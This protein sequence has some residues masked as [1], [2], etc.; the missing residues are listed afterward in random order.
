M[1]VLIAGAG[2]AGLSLGIRLRAAGIDATVIEKTDLTGPAGSGLSLFRNGL[3]ALDALGLG[4]P[5]RDACGTPYVPATSGLRSSSGR[6][7]TRT[8][9]RITASLLVVDREVLRETLVSLLPPDA[10]RTSEAVIRVRENGGV[11]TGVELSSGAAPGG[12]DVIVGADG[13]RSA[14][15]RSVWGDA[16]P[17]VRSTGYFACRGMTSDPLETEYGGEIWGRATRF[18]IAPLPDG[19]VYWFAVAGGEPV[20]TSEAHSWTRG[21]FA[22]WGPD[23]ER[24][25]AATPQDAVQPLPIVELA[26]PL[27]SFVD[28]RVALVGD[29]AHAM[30]PNLGQGANQALEDVAV[31]ADQLERAQ[32]GECSIDEALAAYDAKRRWRANLVARASRLIGTF[33]QVETG[34]WAS[35][36]DALIR[37]R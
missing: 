24:I 6:M 22:G 23:V 35:M 3:R 13:I 25:I 33:A 32:R 27:R 37:P 28:D 10:L 1:R 8:S 14:I 11:A 16:D 31:L 34:P 26:A 21:T 2:I 29:A 4:D 9:D 36:R 7:V 5:V 12:Y 19:R 20:A 15:R 30:T 18:G 17:G